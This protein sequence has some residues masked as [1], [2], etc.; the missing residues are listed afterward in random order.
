MSMYTIIDKLV[1]E[2]EAKQQVIKVLEDEVKYI[3]STDEYFEDTESFSDKL[4][5]YRKS[6]EQDI[7]K[8]DDES[9][10]FEM[11]D[12]YQN[13]DSFIKYIENRRIKHG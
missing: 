12:V 8:E 13:L 1:E 3:K 6:M 5:E 11:M 4:I 9:K 7:K 10:R 2:K